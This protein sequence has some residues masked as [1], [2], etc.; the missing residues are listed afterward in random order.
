MYCPGC[1]NPVQLGNKSDAGAVMM[2]HNNK[3]GTPCE[4]IGQSITEVAKQLQ[5]A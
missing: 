3:A 1:K 4:H 2:A 5:Q